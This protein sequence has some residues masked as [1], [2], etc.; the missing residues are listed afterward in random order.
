MS[1]ESPVPTSKAE[2]ELPNPAPDDVAEETLRQRLASCLADFTQAQDDIDPIIERAKLAGLLVEPPSE[3]SDSDVAAWCPGGKVQ[4]GICRP[5]NNSRPR[6]MADYRVTY[7]LPVGEMILPGTH[8]SGFDKEAPRTPSSE[9]CQDVSIYKQLQQGVRALDLRVRY[10]AG[11]PP[12]RRFAIFHKST[13]GRHVKADVLGMLK[14]YRN[15]NNAH[16]EIVV[17]DFHELK[18]FTPDAHREL[19]DLIKRELGE[20]IVPYSLKDAAHHQLLLNNRVNVIA[21]NNSARDPLF[22]PGVDQRWIGD[23][24]PGKSKMAAFIREVGKESKAF[25]Q[26]RSV[27][28]AFYSLPMFVPKDLSEDVMDWFAA[29]ADGGPIAGH[30]IINTDWSLRQRLVDN[31]IYANMIRRNVRG[32][33]VIESAPDTH[34]PIVQTNSYG[35]Y[36]VGNGYWAGRLTFAENISDYTSIQVI[37]HRADWDTV[38]EWAG[39]SETLKK[40]ESLYFRVRSRRAPE[41]LAKI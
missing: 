23:N 20:T 31:V 6:W 28:A 18:D 33:H 7:A 4:G 41:L 30:Y 5:P 21:Y 13:S 24:T 10:Y 11:N 34:G 26:L 16:D 37:Q 22:W 38:V 17:L 12:D 2:D 39:G 1:S 36:R 14:R 3:A 35:I 25:G 29:K 9:T 40:G 8:H 19:A 27:Q 32:A 15:E